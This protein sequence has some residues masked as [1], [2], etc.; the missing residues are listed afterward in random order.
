M[1][2]LNTKYC[3]TTNF[4]L[5]VIFTNSS[6]EKKSLKLQLLKISSQNCQKRNWAIIDE[7]ML[8]SCDTDT[9]TF[10]ICRKYNSYSHIRFNNKP[11]LYRTTDRLLTL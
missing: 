1:R 10:I 11:P 2:N 3:R 7:I 5:L 9:W 6:N 8:K 4:H